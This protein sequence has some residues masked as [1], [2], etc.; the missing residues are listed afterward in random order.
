VKLTD[1]EKRERATACNKAWEAANPEKKKRPTKES[2]QKTTLKKNG[3][4]LKNGQQ[5]TKIK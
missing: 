3:N 1:K 2:G 4:Q 5:R